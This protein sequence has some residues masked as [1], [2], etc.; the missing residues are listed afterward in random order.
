MQNLGDEAVILTPKGGGSNWA[1]LDN[2]VADKAVDV[3]KN[4]HISEELEEI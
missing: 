3:D 1:A 2:I 4:N